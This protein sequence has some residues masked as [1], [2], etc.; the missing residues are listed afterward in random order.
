MILCVSKIAIDFSLSMAILSVGPYKLS[1]SI[2]SLLFTRLILTNVNQLA[3]FFGKKRLLKKE[4]KDLTL[5]KIPVGILLVLVICE[6]HTVGLS[7][8]LVVLFIL[9]VFVEDAFPLFNLVS[10]L[11]Y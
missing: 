7:G 10:E 6:A 5:I 11:S 2:I 9:K 3:N 8:V 4:E 1:F